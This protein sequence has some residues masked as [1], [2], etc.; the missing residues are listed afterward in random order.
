MAVVV[1]SNVNDRPL[2]P[3]T[4]VMA[5]TAGACAPSAPPSVLI[6]NGRQDLEVPFGG[7]PA[8]P[9]AGA[10]VLGAEATLANWA[11]RDRCAASP[12][13]SNASPGGTSVEVVTYPNCASGRFVQGWWVND[14][15][16]MPPRGSGPPLLLQAVR[17]ALGRG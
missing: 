13:K 9:G 7:A 14:W 12:Q 2:A 10:A 3:A 16:H 1:P 8:L 4:G 17:R 5:A 6:V 11:R 15:S